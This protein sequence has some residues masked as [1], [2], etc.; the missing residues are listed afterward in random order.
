M[1]AH[2]QLREP[3]HS[4]R[5]L[6]QALSIYLGLIVMETQLQLSIILKVVQVVFTTLLLSH[7]Q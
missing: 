2:T 4:R 5:P 6:E 7:H 3:L 1:T